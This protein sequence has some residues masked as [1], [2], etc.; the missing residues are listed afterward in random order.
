MEIDRSRYREVWSNAPDGQALCAL[1]NGDVG[2]L[3]YLRQPGDAGF[4]SR[5]PDYRGPP[6]AMIEYF[7]ENGQRDEYPRAWALPIATIHRAIDYFRREHAPPPF[8]AWHHDSHDG[9]E[10]GEG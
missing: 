1:I 6:E 3:M 8:I 4:S 10:V 9:T 7:L 5:N 2:M